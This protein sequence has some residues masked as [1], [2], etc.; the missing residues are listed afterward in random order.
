MHNEIRA[1]VIFCGVQHDTDANHRT[2][3]ENKPFN[4]HPNGRNWDR[5]VFSRHRVKP[6]VFCL[7]PFS[8]YFPSSFFMISV[9]LISSMFCDGSCLC[10]ST[11]KQLIYVTLELFN[12]L[13]FL[14][15]TLKW[16]SSQ[17]F[18]THMLVFFFYGNVT[19]KST[20]LI[21]KVMPRRYPLMGWCG[22]LSVLTC[23]CVRAC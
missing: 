5:S 6:H 4:A 8:H 7:D 22:Q 16:G 12:R 23:C 21:S 9:F 15:K 11:Q 19:V 10:Q 1:K 17:V 2:L 3:V 20:L 14:H 18:S 13:F